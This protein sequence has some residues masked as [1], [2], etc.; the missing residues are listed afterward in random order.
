MRGAGA[1]G[2]CRQG[3]DGVYRYSIGRFASAS[4]LFFWL[5]L[6]RRGALM[7]NVRCLL[8][9]EWRGVLRCRD[10]GALKQ[11]FSWFCEANVQIVPDQ[12]LMMS[13]AASISWGRIRGDALKNDACR[14]QEL[15]F[16]LAA[17]SGAPEAGEARANVPSSSSCRHDT[18]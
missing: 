14:V 3:G 12:A 1:R 17:E 5:E 16:F 6:L 9:H 8:S 7:Q 15:S 18:P 10:A 13:E 2:R 4:V 11:Q